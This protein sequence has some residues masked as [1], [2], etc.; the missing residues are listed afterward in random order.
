MR[1]KEVYER[2]GHT[3]RTLV[4]ESD[5]RMAVVAMKSGAIREHRANETASIHMLS[6]HV[7]VRLR[8]RFVDLPSS[9]LLVLE[10]GVPHNLE[11]TD[12]SLYSPL[13]GTRSPDR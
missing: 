4:R 13:V 2:E 10:S 8:D 5:L 3:S 7:C 6:G 9:R 1:G 12:E 11:A